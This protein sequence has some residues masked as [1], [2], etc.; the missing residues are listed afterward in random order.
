MGL[1]SGGTESAVWECQP[2]AVQREGTRLR[3]LLAG[4]LPR[5]CSGGM[6]K[7]RSESLP[8]RAWRRAGRQVSAY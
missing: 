1:A 4:V 2:Y 7:A 6:P 5:D 3:T 8:A